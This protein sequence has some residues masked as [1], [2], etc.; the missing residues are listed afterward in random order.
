MSWSAPFLD[1]HSSLSGQL[2]LFPYTWGSERTVSNAIPKVCISCFSGELCSGVY[3][4]VFSKWLCGINRAMVWSS[5]CFM[6]WIAFFLFRA[7]GVSIGIFGVQKNFEHQLDGFIHSCLHLFMNTDIR[8]KFTA[9]QM[10]IVP[11]EDFSVPP[12]LSTEHMVCR[13]T[14]AL[15]NTGILFSL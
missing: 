15:S 9:L 11:G 14:T 13:L 12:V 3:R 6:Q 7:V 8:H 5:V 4:N 10:P 1:F 2:Y